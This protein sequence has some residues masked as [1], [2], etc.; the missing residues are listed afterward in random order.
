MNLNFNKTKQELKKGSALT[1][2]LLINI[3]AYVVLK[4]ASLFLVLF[5]VD[6]NDV[7]TFLE[8]PS[9]LGTLVIQPWTLITYMFMHLNFGHIL[10]NML[11]LY[12]FGK[13]FIEYYTQ[14]QLLT[15]Y[16]LSG[17]LGGLVYILA[18]NFFPYFQNVVNSSFL[19]GASASIMGII[20][21]SA[22][23]APNYP[24]N[25]L[26]IGQ[27]KLKW[28]AI[29]MIAISVFGISSN[30]AGGEFSHIGGALGGLLFVVA[31]KKVPLGKPFGIFFNRIA[32]LFKKRK[33]KSHMN[34][35]YQAAKRS[36]SDEDYNQEKKQNNE[37]IDAILDKIK[38]KG[39]ASLTEKEKKALFEKSKKL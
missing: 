38:K 29:V 33:M 14:K 8:L 15:T 36:K 19:L 16:I 31:L 20:V 21:A 12:W 32:G 4:L 17:L 7:F 39:Y 34:Y 35:H 27:I 5:N 23:T 28:L 18:Y 6:T 24:I 13:I 3:G 30:N 25:L 10:F 37:I 1:Y 9:R 2:L 26:F 11:A 22:L